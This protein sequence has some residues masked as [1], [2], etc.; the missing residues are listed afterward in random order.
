MFVHEHDD[1][2]HAHEHYHGDSGNIMVTTIG[3][4]LHSVADGMALGASLYCK[5]KCCNLLIVSGKSGTG[6]GLLIF[7][8]I[9]MHKAPAAI[10]FGTF[11]HHEGLK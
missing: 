1:H 6:L 4:V 2:F 8:A 9:L 7:I 11:L 5:I 3:L 10:G